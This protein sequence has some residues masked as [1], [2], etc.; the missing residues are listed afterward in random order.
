MGGN[1][2]TTH[3][4]LPSSA[5]SSS[6]AITTT[7]A[8]LPAAAAAAVAASVAIVAQ[9]RLENYSLHQLQFNTIH[10]YHYHLQQH[11]NHLTTL[12]TASPS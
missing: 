12:A 6:K 7:A 8:T 11:Y 5:S 4:S 10:A 1:V 3:S 2:N 9:G